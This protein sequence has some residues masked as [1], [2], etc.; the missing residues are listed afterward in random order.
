M[1]ETKGKTQRLMDLLSPHDKVRVMMR[2]SELEKHRIGRL[3]GVRK[4]PGKAGLHKSR[5][6]AVKSHEGKPASYFKPIKVGKT[7]G[8]MR[9]LCDLGPFDRRVGDA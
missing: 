2:K 9:E 5:R 8:T 6:A 4:G 3:F 7:D 1:E